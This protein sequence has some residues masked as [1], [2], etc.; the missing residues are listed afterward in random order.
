[1]GGEED[2]KGGGCEG[3]K[4]GKGEK[5]MRRGEMVNRTENG[6]EREEKMKSIG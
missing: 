2:R 6:K 4:R 3:D 5:E 1:M